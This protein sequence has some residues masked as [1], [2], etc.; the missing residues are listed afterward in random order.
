MGRLREQKGKFSWGELGKGSI[1][2]YLNL[3]ETR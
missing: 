2:G 3:P 1:E